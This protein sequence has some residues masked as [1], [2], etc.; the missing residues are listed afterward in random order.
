M[1]LEDQ[2]TN[3]HTS[4]TIL[5]R[6]THSFQISNCMRG[7]CGDVW[8][9]YYLFNVALTENHSPGKCGSNSSGAMRDTYVMLYF[10]FVKN[11]CDRS[12]IVHATHCACIISPSH[13]TRS[14]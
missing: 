13:Q 7:G 14:P 10:Y 5:V 9:D 1:H 8:F 2:H 4:P 6:N 3:T 11:T 12:H